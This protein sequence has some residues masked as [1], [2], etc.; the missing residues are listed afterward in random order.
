MFDYIIDTKK[1]LKNARKKKGIMFCKKHTREN[2]KFGNLY[3]QNTAIDDSEVVAVNIGDDLQFMAIDYLYSTFISDLG[4]VVK[5]QIDELKDYQGESIILPLNWTLFDSHFMSNDKIAISE[6]IVPVFLGMTIESASHKE[7][8]FNDY[9]I[10]YLK[11][12]EPVGC[13]DEYTANVLKKHHIKAYLNGCMTAVFPKRE[14]RNQDKVFFVDVPIGLEQYIPKEI[15]EKYE[16][17]T[18]QYY[19]S[20]NLPIENVLNTIKAQ[21]QRYAD[22]AALIVTSRL[23]VASPCMAMGI[24]VIFAKD[25]IDARFGWLDK[26]MKLY[27]R[28]CY[29]RIDWCPEPIEYEE[30]KMLIIQNAVHR[31]MGIYEK[32][33]MANEVDTLYSRRKRKDYINFQET[34]YNH[35]EKAILYLRDNFDREDHIVYSIWGINNAA[36]NFYKYMNRE[37]PNAVLKNVIDAY[38]SIE[39]HGIPTIKPEDLKKEEKEVIF[40]LPVK[41][42]N[43]AARTFKE[44]GITSKYYVCCGD[45]FI[46]C[47]AEGEV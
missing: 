28:N 27:D 10:A 36:E 29:N 24:P 41:A 40:V 11:R 1:K 45:Q 47:D 16:V 4:K 30:I 42:S 35:Y 38:K 37:Y 43:E 14:N 22:E 25:Q 13:R 26:Y 7:K 9:N 46:G 3:W 20:K 32:Y 17:M 44:K 39:F 31:I 12:Y 18:Q 33:T 15:Q 19:F 6:N 2:M 8:Y 23:H 21:Y 34:I 5:L